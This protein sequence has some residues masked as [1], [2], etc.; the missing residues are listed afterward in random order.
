[1]ATRL[2]FLIINTLQVQSFRSCYCLHGY[3]KQKQDPTD[4]WNLDNVGL[5]QAMIASTFVHPILS[6][7]HNSTVLPY[8]TSIYHKGRYMS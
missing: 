8:L 7:A 1:M 6:H 5:C 4:T 2:V 3:L